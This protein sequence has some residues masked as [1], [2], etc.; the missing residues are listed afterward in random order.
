M[1]TRQHRIK[2]PTQR[3]LISVL[4]LR[5]HWRFI[6]PK[7]GNHC[8]FSLLILT[9]FLPPL[10]VPRHVKILPSPS[11]VQ[12]WFPHYYST[13]TAIGFHF[14]HFKKVQTTPR[15]WVMGPMIYRQAKCVH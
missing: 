15:G 9:P 6:W 11:P 2:L 10:A 5:V 7:R 3:L 14:Y 12:W 13:S 1:M 4:P 8:W